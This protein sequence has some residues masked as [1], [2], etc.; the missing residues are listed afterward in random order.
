MREKKQ[1]KADKEVKKKKLDFKD[2]FS[3]K[4]M[5]CVNE[6]VLTYFKSQNM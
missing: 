3:K 1:K 4:K 2:L 6:K 5:Y